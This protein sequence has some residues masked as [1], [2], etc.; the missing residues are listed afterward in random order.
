MRPS[1]EDAG[2]PLAVATVLPADER[3]RVD[4]AGQGLYRAIHRESVEDILR[5]LRHGPP[6]AVL[7]SPQRCQGPE[8]TRVARLVR[9][10]PAVPAVALVSGSISPSPHSLLALGQ[11]GVRSVVDVRS[12]SGWM[13]LRSLLTAEQARGIERRALAGI[14]EDVP[15]A[16]PGCHRFFHAIFRE[17][18]AVGTIRRLCR[19]LGVIPSTFM[20]RFFRRHLPA[21][22]R[23][24]ATARLVYAASLFENVGLSIASVALRLEYS[25][26]QSFGRHVRMMLGMTAQQFRESY[27]GE[28][29]LERFRAELVRPYAGTLAGFDPLR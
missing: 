13:E 27:D 28:G 18:G 4:A 16:R 21:P 20:S 5:D 1:P 11:S 22:K 24:L 8:L 19:Q 2:P 15:G 7:L 9:E 3:P 12:S 6:A 10:F 29:M 17:R 14:A 26:P 25:S 23:Y